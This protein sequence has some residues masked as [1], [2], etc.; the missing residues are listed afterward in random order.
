MIDPKCYSELYDIL[1]H[2]D[3]ELYNKIPKK[4]IKIV[5]GYRDKNYKVTIDYSQNI[6]EQGLREDTIILMGIVYKNFLCSP[7]K[8]R[9]IIEQEKNIYKQRELEIRKKYDP[10]NI[11]GKNKEDSLQSSE[12]NDIPESNELPMTLEKESFIKKLINKIKK[13]F[14]K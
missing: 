10:N 6:F 13:F 7:E 8:K 14:K 9:S 4:F 5:N 12:C 3:K 11:F 2:T 1:E